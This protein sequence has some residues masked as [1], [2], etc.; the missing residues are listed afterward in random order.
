MS[1]GRI[2][3]LCSNGTKCTSPG[4]DVSK[5]LSVAHTSTARLRVCSSA[6]SPHYPEATAYT[7]HASAS[8]RPHAPA[9][10]QAPLPAGPPLHTR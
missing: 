5:S 7:T 1:G 6:H 9:R 10:G 4:A 2:Q 8:R 3:E